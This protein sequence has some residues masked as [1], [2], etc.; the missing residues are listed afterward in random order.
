[1]LLLAVANT[2]N[3]IQAETVRRGTELAVRALLGASSARL[4][5]Q[6]MSETLLVSAIAAAIA[7]V[8]SAW[9]L[10]ALAKAVPYLMLF[11][12]LR[13]IGIDWR[14]LLFATAVAILAGLGA[15]W[16][17]VLRAMRVDLQSALRGQTSGLPEH[18]RAR[19]T[20]TAA[21]I[22][23][24]FVLLTGAS[25]LGNS[26]LRL[27]R[28]DSGFDPENLIELVVQLPTW[29]YVDELEKRAALERVRVETTRLRDVVNVTI[30]HSMPPGLESH[31]LTGVVTDDGPV[32]SKTEFVSTG[33]VDETFFATLGIPRLSCRTF[34]ARDQQNAPAVSI[35][36]RA[37]AQRFWP[38]R[39]P[40]GRRFRESVKAP[41]LTV[42]G[43]VGDVK[44]GSFERPLG[45]LAYYTPRTQSPTWWYVGLIVRTRSAP[46]P[47][48]P[49]MRSIVQRLLPD[50]P[51]TGVE[52]GYEYIA[53]S[54]SRV[55][56]ATLLMIAFAGVGLMVAL[57]G[58]YGTFWCT[59]SERTREIGVR[60][61]LGAASADILRMVM[62]GSARLIAI[63]LC[64]GLPLAVIATR[65]LRSLLFEVSPSDPTTLGIVTIF[66]TIAALVATYFPARRA[67]GVDPTEALRSQ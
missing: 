61:A 43:V 12:S 13:P 21:Q 18:A 11:Q 33:L 51:I 31:S 53:G 19:R 32:T 3:I 17:S 2:A 23:V 48:V 36:S 67:A 55:R 27:S 15:S 35:V 1:L 29:R 46:E 8:L 49:T 38:G 57:I 39:D 62:A 41:W 22:A 42:V 60:M 10:S 65:A 40:L 45:A 5:R 20:L 4:V 66:L 47:I 50:T 59:V 9:V 44:N 28:V 14:A 63:G 30:S 34:D 24:T 52:T 26:F 64:V 54:N 16:L 37:F 58:V 7:M 56:F 6:M 25:L